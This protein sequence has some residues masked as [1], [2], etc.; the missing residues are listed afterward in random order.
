M[1]YAQGVIPRLNRGIQAGSPIGSGMTDWVNIIFQ[2]IFASFL[3]VIFVYDLRH[4]LIPDKFVYPA[5]FLAAFYQAIAGRSGQAALGAFLL[6]GFFGLLYL[7]SRGRFLGLGDVK[8][9]VFL[10]F[11]IPYPETLVLF[12]LAYVL[13]AL[14]SLLL[15]LGRRKR[16]RDP[17]PFGPFLTSAAFIAMLYGEEMVGWYFGLIGI[18]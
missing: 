10:G 5:I 3:I 17:V 8:L 14:V 7:V 2:F 16:M 6:F 15:L 13:G 18:A 9:G 12:F 1:I 11:L 4:Y